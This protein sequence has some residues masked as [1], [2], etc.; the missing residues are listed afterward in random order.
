M[1]SATLLLLVAFATG[2]GLAVQAVV[3]VRLRD[4]LGSPLWAAA[5]QVVVGLTPLVALMLLTR[6]PSPTVAI[7]AQQPWW[8]WTG[9]LFGVT[10]VLVSILLTPK[11]GAALML[12]T[13]I[14][15]QLTAAMLVDHFGWF[16][17]TPIRMSPLRVAG[18]GLLVLG[19]VLMRRG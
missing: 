3:N 18:A 10:Y 12:A 1:N 15:G 19:V 13:T 14:V 16:G 17:A 5:V 6:V 8:I 7:A 9:G 2:A 11:L 4:A